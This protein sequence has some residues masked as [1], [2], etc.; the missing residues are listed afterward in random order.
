MRHLVIEHDLIQILATPEPW[1]KF[2]GK[3]VLITGGN[4]F[5]PAYMVE[6]LLCRNEQ[7]AS[8]DRTKVVVLVRNEEKARQRFLHYNGRSDLIYLVQDVSKAIECTSRV[9]FIVHA[10]SQASP[11]YFGSDPVGTINANVL[12]T[13]NAL[14]LSERNRQS[15]LLFFSSGEV[16]GNIREDLIPTKETN[17][18]PVDPMDVRSC[19]AESKR[20]GE[21]LCTAWSSQRGVH[22]VVVRPFHTYGPGMSLTDGRVFADFVADIVNR[23]DIVMRSDGS[24]RRAF[25]YLAD[26]T[27]GFFTALLLGQ[28]GTAY[29]VGNPTAEISIRELAEVLSK[30]IPDRH[31]AVVRSSGQHT[32]SAYLKSNISRNSPDV[33]RIAELGWK[34]TTPIQDG[35]ART[36]RSF[37]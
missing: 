22:T 14:N 15:K 31:V 17:Y 29:N 7:I 25:C 18:G 23:R 32:E 4:G 20:L 8:Q 10:A 36:I 21:A 2:N 33:A 16:Y 24:A 11:K 27:V 26:A 12:G 34:P 6:T 1:N 19:Y 5:L 30:L 35:F 28:T 9:D 3:T 13:I 37:L